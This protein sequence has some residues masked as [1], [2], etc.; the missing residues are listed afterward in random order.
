[1]KVL[2]LIEY[3]RDS[4]NLE[5]KKNSGKF[6]QYYYKISIQ[7]FFFLLILPKEKLKKEN[8]ANPII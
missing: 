7:A 1:L 4:Q 6:L 2:F 3:F 5:F 8:L